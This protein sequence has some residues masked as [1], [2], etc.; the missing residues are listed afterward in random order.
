MC[1]D[2]Y[3]DYGQ[4][5]V[6]SSLREADMLLELS[7][8]RLS[9][10]RRLSTECSEPSLK[11]CQMV[12]DYQVYLFRQFTPDSSMCSRILHRYCDFL[13]SEL[14]EGNVTFVADDSRISIL[15]VEHLFTAI[16]QLRS[17]VGAKARLMSPH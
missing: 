8:D 2:P 14:C 1:F 15:N 5:S 11:F 6:E 7:C 17:A 16:E 13:N 10:F 9:P 12:L 4:Q 3:S